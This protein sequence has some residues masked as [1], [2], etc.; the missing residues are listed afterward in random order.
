[1]RKFSRKGLAAGLDDDGAAIAFRGGRI[2]RE[3]RLGRRGIGWNS[4]DQFVP[5]G[6]LQ[7]RRRIDRKDVTVID[8]ADTVAAFDF[9][10]VMCRHDEGQ[11]ARLAKTPEIGPDAVARLGVKSRG[12]FIKY[13]D[14]GIVDEGA[15]DFDSPLHPG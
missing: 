9:F 5:P 10:D 15:R 13:Q 14:L 1:L 11:I 4:A 2:G 3:D 6:G 12:W 8:D 7:G